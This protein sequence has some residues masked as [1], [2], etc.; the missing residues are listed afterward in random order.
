M[1]ENLK[2]NSVE[3]KIQTETDSNPLVKKIYDCISNSPRPY[4][5]NESS[6]GLDISHPSNSKL[7]LKVWPTP[8][9]ELLAW[10][11]KLSAIPHSRDRYSYGGVILPMEGQNLD[12]IDVEVEEWL[13]WLDSGFKAD[14]RPSHWTG[15]FSYDIPV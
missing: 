4:H 5:V 3:S 15:A 12:G 9:S 8:D 10:F 14:Q 2:E 11:Y 6:S 13:V 1:I 7:R